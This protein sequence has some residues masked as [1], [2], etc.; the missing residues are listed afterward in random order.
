M[1]FGDPDAHLAK[2]AGDPTF[3]INLFVGAMTSRFLPW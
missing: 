2:V 1:F 3:L